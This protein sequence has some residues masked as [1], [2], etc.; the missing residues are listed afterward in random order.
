MAPLGSGAGRCH[1]ARLAAALARRGVKTARGEDWKRCAGPERADPDELMSLNPSLTRRK[2]DTSSRQA[3]N[4]ARISM[5]TAKQKHSA[6]APSCPA[7][8][9][10]VAMKGES[11]DYLISLR[12]EGSH[13]SRSIV[14]VALIAPGLRCKSGYCGLTHFRQSSF[15]PLVDPQQMSV[16]P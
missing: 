4:L 1:Y 6:P 2:Q 8:N 12:K 13:R 14:R 16:V 7:T 3:A 10:T 5:P 9:R 15:P 11:G